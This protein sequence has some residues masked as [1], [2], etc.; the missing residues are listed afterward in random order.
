MADDLSRPTSAQLEQLSQQIQL[1]YSTNLG[2]QPQRVE[3]KL[4]EYTLVISVEDA[5]TQPEQILVENNHYEL[6]K[7]VRTRIHEA[8]EP[9]L[10]TLISE[11][12]DVSVVDLL[13]DST[14]HTSRT[15]IVAI[16]AGDLPHLIEP[17]LVNGEK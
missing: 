12:L 14:L 9:Q 4:L 11:I 1:L 6:A 8:I 16:L 3:C 10:Q 15:S 7:Q 2:H 13:I 17:K 5:I